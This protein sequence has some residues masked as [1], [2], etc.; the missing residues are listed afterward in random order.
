M[1]FNYELLTMAQLFYEDL[2]LTRILEKWLAMPSNRGTQAQI[3]LIRQKH[4]EIDRQL[5]DRY[6]K[7]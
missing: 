1:S 7:Q 4:A 2:R 5:K 6:N 3:D